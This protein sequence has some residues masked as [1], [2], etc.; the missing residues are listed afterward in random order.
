MKMNVRTAIASWLMIILIATLSIASSITAGSPTPPPTRDD[1]TPPTIIPSQIPTFLTTGDEFQLVIVVNDDVDVARVEI[2]Y[3]FGTSVP[4]IEEME[5]ELGLQEYKVNLTAPLNSVEQF[6]YIFRAWDSAQNKAETPQATLN[7]IDNDPPEMIADHTPAQTNTGAVLMLSAD[8][9]DNINIFDVRLEYRFG[10]VSLTKVKMFKGEG[11]TYYRNL[12]VPLDSRRPLTYFYRV[13]D[14]FSLELVT[15]ERTIPVIDDV[16][17]VFQIDQTPSEATTGDPLRFS[18]FVQDNIEVEEVKVSYLY[19]LDQFDLNMN[20]GAGNDWTLDVW[21]G[22]I[23]N[24]IVYTFHARDTSGNENSTPPKTIRIIDNDPPVIQ[25]DDT[26]NTAFTGDELV[27]SINVTDNVLV[28][29]AII[30]CNQGLVKLDNVSLLNIGGITWSGSMIVPDSIDDIHYVIH[31]LDAEGNDRTSA[32]KRIE[33]IDDDPPVFGRDLSDGPMETGAIYSFEIEVADNIA[34]DRVHLLLNYGEGEVKNQT[35]V[36]GNGTYQLNV[37][38]DPNNI[39]PVHY[40]FNARDVNGN[41]RKTISRNFS[42]VDRTAPSLPT[43]TLRFGE[44][45]GS[46]LNHRISISITDNI[47]VA[48][49]EIIYRFGNDTVTR[50]AEMS[51]SVKEWVGYVP[52]PLDRLDRLFFSVR[53]WDAE[54]NSNQTV[55]FNSTLYDATPP[56]LGILS[57]ITIYVGESFNVTL[58]VSDNIGV[59][60]IVWTAKPAL[61]PMEGLTV[62]GVVEQPG[63]WKIDVVVK[64]A[65]GNT[66]TSGFILRVNEREVPPP[67]DPGTTIPT[68]LVIFLVIIIIA[69]IVGIVLFFVLRSKKQ[70]DR[71]EGEP[72]QEVLTEEERLLREAEEK[73]KE[74]ERKK[75]EFKRLYG[76]ITPPP[77]S[78]AGPAPPAPEEPPSETPPPKVDLPDQQAPPEGPS[79]E[80][81]TTAPAPKDDPPSSEEAPTS[82]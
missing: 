1:T 63:S 52:I 13:S 45:A 30:E 49:A 69:A 20:L 46:G 37:T 61:F 66:N 32:Q 33:I 76:D 67:K 25:A 36:K 17:P 19:G 65:Q 59:T 12:S 14:L 53:A 56:D 41:W 74:E 8:L 7:V 23:D 81:P 35:M 79:E 24:D 15:P 68:G 40:M 2:E 82:S 31:A 47:K 5:K 70:D 72:A 54:G 11:D 26:P 21:V 80:T 77:S 50:T 51:E 29:S 64:D 6:K 16:L 4:N 27:F 34:V 28:A 48:G 22:P 58:D 10:N 75:E 39:E 60:S 43:I 3:W 78:D 62:G 44:M 9:V 73:L 55:F 42:V 18:V 57:P 38:L 71:P